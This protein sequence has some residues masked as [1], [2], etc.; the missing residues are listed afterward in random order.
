M[1]PSIKTAFEDMI[2]GM[3]PRPDTTQRDIYWN[4]FCLGGLATLAVCRDQFSSSF[5]TSVAE[6]QPKPPKEN[7]I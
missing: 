1:A 7:G 6:L 5:T 3:N 2:A 4:V